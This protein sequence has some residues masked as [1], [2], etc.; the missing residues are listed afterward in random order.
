M[1]QFQGTDL[2]SADAI[3]ED[4]YI[5]TNVVKEEMREEC[6]NNGYCDDVSILITL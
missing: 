2:T 5:G 1:S 6:D 4:G 3:E